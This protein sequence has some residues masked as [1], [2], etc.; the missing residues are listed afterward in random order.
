MREAL[1]LYVERI[2]DRHGNKHGKDVGTPG[3]LAAAVTGRLA[4]YRAYGAGRGGRRRQRRRRTLTS[5][6][7]VHLVRLDWNC[8]RSLQGE[9]RKKILFCRCD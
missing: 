5:D 6:D 1:I 3:Q 2:V 9:E 4:T 7:L 8:T